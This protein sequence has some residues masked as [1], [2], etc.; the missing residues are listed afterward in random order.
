MNNVC[1]VCG[2]ICSTLLS[3]SKHISCTEKISLMDY[4]LKYINSDRPIC[5]FC[6]KQNTNFLNLRLGFSSTC[7]DN[8]CLYQQRRETMI[9]HTGVDNVSRLQQVKDKRLKTFIARFGTT[10]PLK[11]K[12]VAQKLSDTLQSKDQLYWDR[13]SHKL[14][15]TTRKNLNVDHNSQSELIKLQKIKT[16]R[17]HYDCDNPMQREDIRC[18]H[19]KSMME[20][21]GVE[22][23]M[24]SKEIQERS[25]NTM[26]ENH[27]TDNY[28]KTFEFRLFAR[29]QMINRTKSGFRVGQKFSPNKGN[30]EIPFIKELQNNSYYFVD[31]DATIIDYFPDG[32]I[33]ELNL[34]IEFDEPFHNR[35]SNIKR[36]IRKDNDYQ[37]IGLDVMRI[38]ESEWLKNKNGFITNFIILQILILLERKYS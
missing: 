15:L 34:A 10:S 3:L 38:K 31:N 18:R 11:N 27:G 14:M 26:M 5:K 30:N 25:K 29:H 35:P 12:V 4:Y 6:K 24:Q 28:S 17:S 1:L 37:T 7:C 8:D 13:R 16:V 20:H 36:D 23:G 19:R 9:S 2:K 21:H 33:K 32:Y 22:Y